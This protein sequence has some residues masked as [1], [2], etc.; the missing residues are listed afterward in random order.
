MHSG[1]LTVPKLGAFNSQ[2]HVSIKNLHRGV[3][4]HEGNEVTILYLPCTKM[5]VDG[6]D[7]YWAMQLDDSDADAALDHHIAVNVLKLGEHLFAH[8][9]HNCSSNLVRCPLTKHNFMKCFMAALR[10]AGVMEVFMS[11]CF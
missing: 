1:E 5:A 9:A 8:Y 7:V 2:L 11:H 3:V 10:Q 6:E 4:D